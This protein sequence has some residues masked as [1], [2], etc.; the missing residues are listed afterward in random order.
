MIRSYDLVTP[1]NRP[2]RAVSRIQLNRRRDHSDRVVCRGFEGVAVSSGSQGYFRKIVVPNSSCNSI[3]SRTCAGYQIE[4]L[5]TGERTGMTTKG[6]SPLF[7][8]GLVLLVNAAQHVPVRFLSSLALIDFMASS[9]FGCHSS[10]VALTSA[11]PE[12][13]ASVV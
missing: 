1:V 5:S 10:P 3:G 4:S 13:F 9:Y 2:R 6:C 12:L 11:R 8:D 7:D